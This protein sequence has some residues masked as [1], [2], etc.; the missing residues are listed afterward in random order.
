MSTIARASREMI[1]PFDGRRGEEI[2]PAFSGGDYVH[3][4]IGSV[5]ECES[6]R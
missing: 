1:L 4:R 3:G 2:R 6:P 5:P